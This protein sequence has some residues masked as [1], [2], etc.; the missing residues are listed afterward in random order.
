MLRLG[1][2]LYEKNADQKMYP[3]STTKIL[4]A[5]IA[6]E[7][8]SLDEKAVA[9]YNA[10]MTLP[11]GYSNAAIQIG[12]ELTIGQLLQ[13]LLIKSAN[14]A[15]NVIAEHISGSISGFAILMN[16]KAKELGCTKSNF[17]NPSGFHDENHY[18]TARDLSIIAKYCMKNNTFRTIVSS[19][20]CKTDATNKYDER[21][22]PTTNDLLITNNAQKADNYYYQYAIGI[23]TGYTTYAKNCLIAASNKDNFEVIS[24]VL[25]AGQ[26]LEG[27]S[28]KYKDTINLFNYAYDNYT[29]KKL[30][31]S[32]AIGTQITVNKATKDTK[33]LNLLVKDNIISTLEKD[34]DENSFDPTININQ[35]ITAPIKAGD[36]LGTISYTVSGITYTSD[37]VAEHDVEKSHILLTIFQILIAIILIILIS[38]LLFSDHL[39]F[40]NSKKGGK[41]KYFNTL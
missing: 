31:D 37:L 39:R 5:I 25:G 40:F 4:T 11:P 36:V 19:K 7:K 21:I 24:V 12:E 29:I 38:L 9:S 16:E 8:C 26:T 30:R 15:G 27:L 35:N 18:T 41:I 6:L 22:Y 28:A 2:V 32:G 14:D 17:T 33:Q 34:L 20:Y 23:K 3:A 1:K 13:L 10:V